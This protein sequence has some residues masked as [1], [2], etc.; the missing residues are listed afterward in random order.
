MQKFGA[1]SCVEFF[2]VSAPDWTHGTLNSCFGAFH[3]VQVHLGLFCYGSKLGGKRAELVQLMQKFMP[4]SRVWIFCNKC[5]R[6]TP[7]DPKLLFC[8]VVFG[9]IWDRFVALRYSVENGTNCCN[10]CK[11]SSHKVVLEFFATNPPYPLH[12][13][14]HFIVFGCTWDHFVTAWNSVQNGLKWC[15]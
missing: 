15:N 5:T 1:R 7:L 8:S 12:V 13:L 9:C 10:K 14:G 4:R 6:S 2:A 11:S 3:S